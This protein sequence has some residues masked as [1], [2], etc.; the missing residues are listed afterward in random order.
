MIDPFEA[1]DGLFCV[2][3]RVMSGEALIR[4]VWI[5]DTFA[6]HENPNVRRQL[7]NTRNLLNVPGDVIQLTLSR[8]NCWNTKTANKYTIEF[9]VRCASIDAVR[10]VDE[11]L[12][13]EY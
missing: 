2:C 9:V 10:Y 8:S 4:Y 3:L 5:T 1:K 11:C 7:M 13:L 6:I 12:D